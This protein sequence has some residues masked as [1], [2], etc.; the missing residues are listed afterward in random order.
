MRRFLSGRASVP[1]AWIAILLLGLCSL[2][3]CAASTVPGK[4]AIAS[5][6]PLATAAGEE[7][8]AAGGNAF[9]ASVAVA[10]ALAVVEPYSS[11]LGGG[12]FF[13]LYLAE[14][15]RYV[16]VDARE[17]APAAASRDMYLD[18]AGKPMRG[19]SLNG[20]LAAGIPGH[21]AG[22]AHLSAQYGKLDLAT[23]L[24]PAIRYAKEGVPAY[25]RMIAGL[26]FRRKTADKWPDFGKVFYPGG[27]APELG[28]IIRQ[29]DLARS[30]QRI[31]DDGRAG[32]YSGSLAEAMVNGTREAGGIWTLEDF[33]NYRVIERE[34]IQAEILGVKIVSAPP[35]SS[36]G[37]A[38]VN[39]LNM[40]AGFNLVE[41]DATDQVHVLIE[42]MRRTYRDRALYMGD[43]D[44]V[45]IPVE[46]LTHP[47]YAAGQRANIRLDR[48]TPSAELPG[49]WPAGA[50]SNQTT[51]FSVMDADGNRVGATVTIN[52]WYGA[53]FIPPGTGI[54]LNNEMDDFA[55]APAVPNGFNLLG[56]E[57]NAVGPGRRP[58]SS[59]SPTFLESERGVAIL[60]TPGGS[61]IITMVLRAAM[62]WMDG[63]S[64]AEMVTLK[65][66]HHQYYPDSVAYEEG[67]FSEAQVKELTE[68]GHQLRKSRGP[69]GN[70]NVVTWD[71]AS[72]AVEAATDPRGEVE[73]RVY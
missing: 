43:P 13:L 1:A 42:S 4:S 25:K 54:I 12:G 24:A 60:G 10:A 51:H 29:P 70:M 66:F 52:G 49:L 67:A 15:Q 17:M 14:E 48:A 64:A 44:F 21:A 40:A 57:A 72:G 3:A 56:T 59:M 39:M 36:G 46:R 41:L 68:R 20:P 28:Q 38:I 19:A 32:F 53:G 23:C 33:A 31:A 16:F 8:L 26:R 7:I 6:H 18:A 69:F 63:A 35:P 61:R 65:R 37:V 45:S 55:I 62:A 30:L 47:Y 71:F 27:E 9:D 50:E 22:L 11:G 2:S 5:A 58:L 73:G 34:P